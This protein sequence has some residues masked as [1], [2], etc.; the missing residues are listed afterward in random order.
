MCFRSVAGNMKTHRINDI[1]KLINILIVT[2]WD[3]SSF[4]AV[5]FLHPTSDRTGRPFR[6]GLFWSSN[7]ALLAASETLIT[8]FI[9]MGSTAQYM[10]TQGVLLEF[11]MSTYYATTVPITESP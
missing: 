1:I 8:G 5:S 9:K 4:L 6:F 11:H 3:P 7:W 10:Y 2:L